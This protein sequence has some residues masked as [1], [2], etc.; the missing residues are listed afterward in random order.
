MNDQSN[1]VISTA[2]VGLH[3]SLEQ[4]LVSSGQV[5]SL[6][7]H[8]Q[9]RPGVSDD[10]LRDLQIIFAPC[11]EKNSGASTN[12]LAELQGEGPTKA[13]TS[14]SDQ[15]EGAFSDDRFHS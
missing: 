4:I 13:T 12:H 15:D 6:A 9:P 8:S 1:L 10:L 3:N 5:N 14:T 2:I 11:K 7:L